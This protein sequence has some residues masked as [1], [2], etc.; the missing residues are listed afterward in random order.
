MAE[1]SLAR[2]FQQTSRPAVLTPLSVADTGAEKIGAAI[3]GVGNQITDVANQ[4]QQRD[5]QFW[6]QKTMSDIDG[7]N[8]D[9]WSTSVNNA[10]DG[11]P[12]FEK[13]Y[14]GSLDERYQQARDSA[15]SVSARRMLDSELLQHRTQAAAKAQGF[16]VEEKYQYRRD[17]I[18]QEGDNFQQE[19][20]RAPGV[21]AYEPSEGL[22]PPGLV[23]GTVGAKAEDY[24]SSGTTLHSGLALPDNLSEWQSRYYS[25]RDFADG[26]NVQDRSGAVVIAKPV[27]HA[28]DWVTD[29][30]GHGKLDINSGY[31]SSESNLARASSGPDGP[32][33]KGKA[34]DVKVA[35]LPQGER[36]RLYSLFRAAGANAFGFG[37]NFMHVEWRPGTGNG[38]DGDFEWTYPGASKYN[39]VPVAGPDVRNSAQA[40]DPGFIDG[41]PNQYPYL[42]MVKMTAASE[43]GSHDLAAAS[44]TVAREGDGSI[45]YGA[46]GLNSNGMMRSFVDEYGQQLGLTARPG[47]D[48]FNTQ[49]QNA[50]RANPQSVINAQL[51]F[52]QAHIVGPAQRMIAGAGAADVSNDPRVIAFAGDMMVQYGPEIA[53]KRL[54]AGAGAKSA[55]A[56]INAVSEDARRNIDADFSTALG[57]DPSMRQGLLNRIDRRAAGAMNVMGIQTTAAVGVPRWDGPTPD[58]EAIPGYS[59]RMRRIDAMVDT[60]GGSPEDRRKIKRELKAGVVR[61][62]LTRVSQV[63]PPAAM[64]ALMSGRYDDDLAISDT[65]SLYGTAQESYRKFEADIRRQHKELMDNLRTETSALYSDEKASLAAT[66]QGLGKLTDAHRAVMTDDQ[67]SDLQYAK[68]QYDV[69][70]QIAGAKTQDLPAILE[71][72]K[73]EGQGFAEE[74]RR[75]DFAQKQIDA[76]MKMQANDPAG[77]V[78]GSSEQLSKL[79]QDA[80]SSNDPQ[81]ISAAISTIRDAQAHIGISPENIRSMPQA[82]MVQAEDLLQKSEDADQAFARFMELR[83]SYGDQMDNVISDMETKGLTRGWKD[84][85]DLVSSGNVLL[86]K[87]LARVVHANE[88][89]DDVKLGVRLAENGQPEVARMIFDGRLRRHE[90]AGL[91]PTGKDAEFDMNTNQVMNDYLGDSL[92][93]APSLMAAAREAGL[94]VYAVGSNPGEALDGTRLQDALKAVT[95]GILEYNSDGKTGK[96]VAPKPGMTQQQF[97]SLIANVSNDDLKGALI[98]YSHVP[99]PVTASMLQGQIQF[100]SSGN[101]RYMLRY[102]GAGLARK[103]DGTPYELDLLNLMPDLAKRQKGLDATM[104]DP[105]PVKTPMAPG[106]VL[107]NFDEN[108]RWKGPTQ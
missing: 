12:D 78:L 65:T 74:Q 93:Q 73:P 67:K 97:D 34:M 49:W 92:S 54:A 53:A 106:G 20:F 17:A 87:S 16:A 66:G 82:S 43:T 33:T 25:P 86:A 76:R 27:L 60:M 70:K 89:K 4:I 5:D 59:D 77:Y 75:Y 44:M 63:N 18:L 52:H 10:K 71:G 14:L 50:V 55:A 22:T 88:Y 7:Y 2:Y 100:V 69:T 21:P 1:T 13:N 23:P 35:G 42:G 104:A 61:S 58:I 31:R 80:I 56:F 24:Y 36:D 107:S 28:L 48:E 105:N 51:K 40:G 15:P 11:A 91:T 3:A 103:E 57:N 30:F 68:F 41:N 79:W 98:G 47:S 26:K 96:F 64:A 8:R 94:S 108:G 9:L 37:Q 38:R 19:L 29:Q 84:V 90:I 46:L 32:H 72:L 85:N 99:E 83:A 39:R 95:G 81:K 45:S 102:P 101:G 6:V 62:W